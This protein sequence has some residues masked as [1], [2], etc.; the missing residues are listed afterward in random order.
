MAHKQYR[1]A[2]EAIVEAENDEEMDRISDFIMQTIPQYG[3]TY[4]YEPLADKEVTDND[5]A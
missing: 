1:I 2:I 5:T 3:F 4:Y